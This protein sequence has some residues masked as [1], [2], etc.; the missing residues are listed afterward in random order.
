MLS[1]LQHAQLDQLSLSSIHYEEENGKLLPL[2]ICK[3]YY[4]QG[5]G[6]QSEEIYDID[7]QTESG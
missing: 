2:I 5:S 1:V 4:K 3:E 6:K 7:A